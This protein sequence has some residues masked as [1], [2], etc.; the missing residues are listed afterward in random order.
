[1]NYS[2]IL[3]VSGEPNSIFLE[4]FF[5]SLKFKIKSPIILISSERLI[6]LQMKK[7]KFNKKIKLLNPKKISE[8]KLNNK[9]INLIN[10]EYYP[11][12]AFEK[13]LKN[14]KICS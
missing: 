8:Y 10:I 3:I 14:Q 13:F 5:K 2:P 12:K 11:T 6:K 9:S 1:M 7:L 4:I